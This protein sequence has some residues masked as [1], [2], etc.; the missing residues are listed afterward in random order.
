M[1][2]ILTIDPADPRP[3]NSVSVLGSGD[4]VYA[5]LDNLYV[6]SYR[7]DDVIARSRSRAPSK[8]ITRIHKFDI[9][10][11]KR[12][13]YVG[14][15][16]VPGFLL[17]QFSLSERDGYLR[18]ASTLEAPWI[19]SEGASA[20]QSSVIVLADK[21]GR[22]VPIGAVGHLGRGERIY[23]VRFVGPFGYVITFRQIDPLFVIDLRKPA[24]PRLRGKLDMTG[25]SDYLHP[26]SDTL[27]LGIGRAAGRDGIAKGLQFSVFDVSNP[28]RPRRLSVASVGVYG[29]SPV[30]TD[31]H[32]FLYWAPKRLVV[33]PSSLD[34]ADYTHHVEG[35]MAVRMSSSGKLG[36]PFRLTHEGRPGTGIG[37]ASILRSLVIGDRLITVSDFGVLSSDLDSFA[38]LSWV[39]FR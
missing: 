37:I 6:T 24:R 10:D 29:Y 7:L 38:T 22:L 33:V 31:H 20:T 23:S 35:A 36:T 13:V 5:S 1:L 16:E 9:R 30:G 32:A 14:S 17:N 3:D 21:R 12:A 11:P 18:V 34:N 4:I 26:I 19:A 2:T 27:L 28:D 15:G 8:P 39:R 25:F